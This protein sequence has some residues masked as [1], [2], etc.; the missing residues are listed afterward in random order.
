MR[1]C[2]SLCRG[3]C[4]GFATR[5]FL[6]LGGGNSSSST[7]GS[8]NTG[9]GSTNTGPGGASMIFG[10]FFTPGGAHVVSVLVL[11]VLARLVMW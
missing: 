10:L 1:G 6:G 2:S 5:A 11:V 3:T 7:S 9:S 8:A 4:F